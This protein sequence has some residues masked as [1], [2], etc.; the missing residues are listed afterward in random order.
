MI[1][2]DASAAVD[3]L[4]NL[5]PNATQIQERIKREDSGDTRETLHVPH[6][7]TVEVLHAL[8]RLTLA[9]NVSEKR[10]NRAVN[11]MLSMRLTRYPHEPFVKRIWE[12]K[13]NIS[14][15]DAAY[16]A[17]AEALDAPLITTDRRLEQAPTHG[18][19]VELYG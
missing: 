11:A 3:A 12:L 8:R 10:G 13:E 16:I 7:F 5:R 9:G 1:V 18:A 14:A 17:L 4:L 6:L 2:L 15:Y 19:K